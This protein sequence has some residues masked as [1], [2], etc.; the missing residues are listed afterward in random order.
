VQKTE[1]HGPRA[2]RRQLLACT[3]VTSIIPQGEG[4]RGGQ[5]GYPYRAL[6]DLQTG[7]FALCKV[8]GRPGEAYLGTDVAVQLPRVCGG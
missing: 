8:S 3:A 5:V 4:S 1:C 7:R 6:V 2:P